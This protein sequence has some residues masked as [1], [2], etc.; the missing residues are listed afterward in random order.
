MDVI[1]PQ[2]HAVPEVAE[3]P[4]DGV[5]KFGGGFEAQSARMELKR[6][7]CDRQE[8]RCFYCGAGVA[9]RQTEVSA[10]ATF[11]HV[12]PRSARGPDNAANL[13]IA[14]QPCNQHVGAMSVFEK[15]RY[16]DTL[17]LQRHAAEQDDSIPF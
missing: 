10:L 17:L 14:C 8:W 12:V 5:T 15:L 2:D 6:L 4:P 1:E 16:R 11:E 13:V 7:L 3:P 9:L